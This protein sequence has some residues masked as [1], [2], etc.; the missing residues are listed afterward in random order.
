MEGE[1]VA[2]ICKELKKEDYILVRVSHDND[3]STMAQIR[4]VYPNCIEELDVG[5]AAK[6][7]NKKVIELGKEYPDLKGWGERAKRRFQDLAYSA[8]GDVEYF[9]KGW[10]TSMLHWCNIHTQCS[11]EKLDGKRYQPLIIASLAI[12]ALIALVA[13]IKDQAHKFVNGRSSNICEAVNNKIT[14]YAP[15]RFN[16]TETYDIRAN[17]AILLQNEGIRILLIMLKLL[18]LPISKKQQ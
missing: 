14:V 15:K 18:N 12:I 3:A 1:G 5:H 17:L 10:D 6:N 9:K 7:F 11:H 2:R 16:L 8:N 13:L 4:A